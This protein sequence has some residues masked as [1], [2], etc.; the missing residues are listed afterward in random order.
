MQKN[1]PEGDMPERS[2]PNVGNIPTMAPSGSPFTD[3]EWKTL[4]TIPIQVGRAVMAVSPSGGIG[5][6]KE[7]MA[8]RDAL[9]KTRAVET[10]NPMLRQ[11]GQHLQGNMESIWSEAEH[12]FKARWD[13]ATV[14]QTAITACQQAVALLRKAS[15]EDAMAYKEFIYSVAQKVAESSTEGGF[16]GIK[17]NAS[18]I[19][20]EERTLLRDV[21]NALGIQ[22]SPTS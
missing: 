22:H 20:P 11:L 3:T 7:V 9:E 19:S 12:A 8:L 16:M 18:P 13:S 21:A 6:T 15:P 14:R 4:V 10:K 2:I 17:A 1:T 5:M